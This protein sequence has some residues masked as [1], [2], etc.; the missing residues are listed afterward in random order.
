MAS[1]M[2]L[3]L[4]PGFSQVLLPG[5]HEKPFQRFLVAQDKP[6]KRFGRRVLRDTQLQLGVNEI[7]TFNS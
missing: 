2:P 7:S 5:R 6:L 3:S 4:T 1:E